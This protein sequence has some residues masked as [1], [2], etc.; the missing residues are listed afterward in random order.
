MI[1]NHRN[2]FLVYIVSWWSSPSPEKSVAF[3]NRQ[4]LRF[5]L[6]GGA[7][8]CIDGG[9]LTVL[10]QSGWDILPA[11]LVSFAMAVT[12]T[13]AAN[14]FWTFKLS[15]HISLTREYIAYITVQVIGALINLAIFFALMEMYPLLRYFPLA[16][17]AFGAAISLV[18]NYTVSKKYAFK[19]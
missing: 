17:L 19:G 1:V 2:K 10:M 15:R 14:R 3:L 9:L 18:F 8:F 12:C 5:I 16:P 6:V 4:L 11:R 7:G 13:W